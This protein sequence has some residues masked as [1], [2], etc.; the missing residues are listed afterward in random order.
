MLS[1]ILSIPYGIR[2]IQHDI[3]YESIEI[4][5][6]KHI[7]MYGEIDDCRYRLLAI[8][9]NSRIDQPGIPLTV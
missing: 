2:I 3:H 4:Y 8:A 1:S 9:L 5:T 6:R 7:G